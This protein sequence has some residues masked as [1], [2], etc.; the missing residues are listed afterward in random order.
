MAPINDATFLL[1]AA[2]TYNHYCL[3]GAEFEEDMNRFKYIKKILYRYRKSGEINERLVL[4]HLVILFNVFD[5]KTC[6]RMLTF[7]LYNYMDELFTF[8]EFMGHLPKKIES[9][10]DEDNNIFTNEYR[11]DSNLQF[12]LQDILRCN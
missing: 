5:N 2:R 3:D 7:K 6:V 10:G 9:I 4:N 11:R 1:T 12:K 8:L